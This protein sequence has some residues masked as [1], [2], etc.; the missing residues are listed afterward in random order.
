MKLKSDFNYE[1]GSEWRYSGK[2]PAEFLCR[3]VLPAGCCPRWLRRSQRVFRQIDV[4]KVDTD[5]ENMLHKTGCPRCFIG[6]RR[7]PQI[8][9]GASDTLK[10]INDILKVK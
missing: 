6:G 10:A 7:K 8:K 9:M 4:Y 1:A 5:K 3:L 2:R